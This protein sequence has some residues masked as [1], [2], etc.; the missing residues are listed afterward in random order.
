[1]HERSV[2]IHLLE[3]I[4]KHACEA[5]AERVLA[6]ELVLGEQSHIVPESLQ[7]HFDHLT[8]E[9]NSLAQG[10]VLNIRKVPMKMDCDV[11]D[12]EYT[13]VQGTLNCPKCNNVGTLLDKG[14]ELFIKSIE[15]EP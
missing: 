6:V 13:P 3:I 11:C 4:D 9:L 15:V 5:K 7:L 1:M 12:E 8:S 2:A 14:D 10:A